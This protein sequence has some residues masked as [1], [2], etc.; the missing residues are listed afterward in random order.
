[1]RVVAIYVWVIAADNTAAW[2]AVILPSLGPYPSPMLAG[3]GVQTNAIYIQDLAVWLPLAAVAVLWLRRRQARGAVIVGA[4]LGLWVIEGVSVATDQ[5]FGVQA[6]PGSSVVS[7]SLVGPFLA[8]AAIG[9][10]PLWLLLRGSATAT[11]GRRS[12]T[13]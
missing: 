6:D 5:W 2:L 11:R 12:P 13:G 8:L 4:L 3:T 9:L 7:L 10:V 1:M